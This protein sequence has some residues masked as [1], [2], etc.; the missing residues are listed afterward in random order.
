LETSIRSSAAISVAICSA[1]RPRKAR[2][3]AAALTLPCPRQA[4]LDEAAAEVSV[5]QARLDAAN[6]LAKRRVADPF[7]ALKPRKSP[8]FENPRQTFPQ[9]KL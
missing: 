3:R 9:A 7:L 6:R 2:A 5:D 4:L 8:K 1:V